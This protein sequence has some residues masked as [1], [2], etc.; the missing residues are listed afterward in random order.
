MERRTII[1]IV[2]LCVLVLGIPML[3]FWEM[4]TAGSC[5]WTPK[6]S[7]DF[8]KECCSRTEFDQLHGQ[9]R[10]FENNEFDSVVVNEYKDST[11]ISVFKVKVDSFYDSWDKQH[12]VRDFSIYRKLY[13]DHIY[14][15]VADKENVYTL[16]NMQMIVWAQGRFCPDC[17]MGNYIIDST[18]FLHNA[19]PIFKKKG[20][21]F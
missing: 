14:K 10:G 19:N 20:Y 5:E 7:A 8:E 18:A 17:T 13:T 15:F 4:A 12:K 21:V 1:I 2:G 9:F 6:E 16:R 11:L 3:F